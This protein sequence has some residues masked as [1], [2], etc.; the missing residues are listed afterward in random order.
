MRSHFISGAAIAC[1]VTGATALMPTI[2]AAQ[3]YDS[4][5]AYG[6]WTAGSTGGSGFGTWSFD[7]TT[8]PGGVSDPGAQQELSSAGAIGT[9]W[10]LF[11]LTP[12]VGAGPGIS[13]VGRG[14]SE[15]GGLQPGQT[16]E[17]VIQNPSVWYGTYNPNAY[18]GGYTGWDILLGNL[19]DNNVAGVNT[20][21]IRIQVFNYFNSAMNWAG[22]D[23]GSFGMSPMTGPTTAAA[24]AK[25]D[26]TLTSSTTYSLLVTRLSDNATFTRTGTL[27]SS[28]PINYVNYRLYNTPSSGPNDVA[29][30]YGISYMEI[31]PEPATFALLGMGIGGLLF[32]RRRK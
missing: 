18:Q 19:T 27:G 4:A 28:L 5:S 32:L 6:S 21:A 30:N 9:A 14:I 8:D 12:P 2:G 23:A 3:A 26:L 10:T 16:F 17:T 22:N 24:G 1:A 29:N 15:A 25:I 7:G 31:V 20:S 11:N 13:D